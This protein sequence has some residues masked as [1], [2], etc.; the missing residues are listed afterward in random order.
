LP[1]ALDRGVQFGHQL[2]ASPIVRVRS[3]RFE[4][5]HVLD[6]LHRRVWTHG[7]Y[8]VR[9]AGLFRRCEL[10]VRRADGVLE[11]AVVDHPHF[12][13]AFVELPEVIDGA[14][15]VVFE[16]HQLPAVGMREPDRDGALHPGQVAGQGLPAERQRLDPEL[17]DTPAP[18]GCFQIVN[19]ARPAHR[20]LDQVGSAHAATSCFT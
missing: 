7:Q 14:I 18:E 15:P 1:D 9:V 17:A 16:Q 11:A 13:D 10:H 5:V 8:F 19:R 20:C 12:F 3:L 4:L 2:V 6:V